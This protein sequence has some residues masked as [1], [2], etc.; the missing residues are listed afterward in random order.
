MPGISTRLRSLCGSLAL[1]SV[2]AL[3][4]LGVA[5]AQRVDVTGTWALSVTTDVTGASQTTTPTV[6]LVQVGDQLTGHYSSE[7]LGEADVTGTVEDGQVTF[8]FAAD[9]QGFTL[10]VSYTGTLDGSDAMEGQIV[11][12]GLGEGV[13]TGER[14]PEVP[15]N[16]GR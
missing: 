8:S 7:T 13:F 1:T 2:V 16:G 14:Q 15:E 5:A 3:M 11:L 4:T 12:A 9:V 6:M 10:D